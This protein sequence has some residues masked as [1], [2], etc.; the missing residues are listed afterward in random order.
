[1]LGCL[2]NQQLPVRW[3]LGIHS[4]RWRYSMEMGCRLDYQG[5]LGVITRFAAASGNAD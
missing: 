2:S 5:V 1:M 3:S 4:R